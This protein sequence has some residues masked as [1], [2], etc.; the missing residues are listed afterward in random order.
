M[1]PLCELALKYGTDKAFRERIPG[2]SGYSA[3]DYTPYYHELLR[4]RD[5]RRVLEVGIGDKCYN[6][7]SLR[8]WAEYFPQAEI[9]GCDI[10]LS[11]FVFDNPRIHCFYCDQSSPVSL[12]Q[13]V[14]QTGGQFDLIVDDG[15]HRIDHQ[16]LTFQVLYPLLNPKGVYII[17]DIDAVKQVAQAIKCAV[18][19]PPRTWRIGLLIIELLWLRSKTV[20]TPEEQKQLDALLNKER[21]TEVVEVPTVAVLH[22]G[23]TTQTLAPQTPKQTV[24][25][26]VCGGICRV[27]VFGQ[28]YGKN[29]LTREWVKK[30]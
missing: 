17:E 28:R 12:Q 29:G 8:M 21:A 5:I 22:A 26:A 27:T 19:C 11:T 3:H 4:D 13:V 18:P 15:S 6:A 24:R 30:N 7:A 16:Q 14:F 20:L 1:T 9:Y 23:N 10:D 25:Y 2:S